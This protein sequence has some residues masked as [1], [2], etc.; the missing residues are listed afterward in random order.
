MYRE[1]MAW[2]SK[3]EQQLTEISN[4]VSS[5][6]ASKQ[7]TTLSPAS[8]RWEDWLESTNFVNIQ[9]EDFAPW[10]EST[11]LVNVRRDALVQEPYSSA[12]PWLKACDSSPQDPV[13][14]RELKLLKEEMAKMKR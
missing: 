5:M 9:G 14:T 8:E 11:D 2:K 4:S 6:Q 10:L 1:L 13:C 3:T 12:Q 7:C